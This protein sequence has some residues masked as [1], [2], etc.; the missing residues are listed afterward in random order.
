MQNIAL[1]Q[2]VSMVGQG[3]GES[4]D[5]GGY[6]VATHTRAKD[7]GAEEDRKVS[8]MKSLIRAVSDWGICGAPLSVFS[9]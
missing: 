4:S 1:P 9:P 6:C 7:L 2:V 5:L 8:P 3:L